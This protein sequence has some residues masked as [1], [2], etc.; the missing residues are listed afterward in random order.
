LIIKAGGVEL[1]KSLHVGERDR[2]AIRA[3][4][5]QVL[6]GGNMLHEINDLIQAARSAI[7]EFKISPYGEKQK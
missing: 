4:I 2:F 3:V 7:N 5:G 1:F 6:D